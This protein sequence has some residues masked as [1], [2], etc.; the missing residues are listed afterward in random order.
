MHI[1][2][3]QERVPHPK[4]A[5]DCKKASFDFDVKEVVTS[6]T[7]SPIVGQCYYVKH[8]HTYIFNMHI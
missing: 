5:S 3:L 7:I 4:A 2:F 1:A 6:P 8:S